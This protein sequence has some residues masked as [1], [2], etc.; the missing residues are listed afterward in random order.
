MLWWSIYLFCL[1][2]FLSK[3]KVV[4]HQEHH[5]LSVKR[6]GTVP[7]YCNVCPKLGLHS[8]FRYDVVIRDVTLGP[9]LN[10][11]IYKEEVIIINTVAE[12]PYIANGQHRNF[13]GDRKHHAKSSKLP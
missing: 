5:L 12:Q 6:N 3:H 11:P 7:I 9:W 10:N 1:S 4:F 8:I 13:C 2:D